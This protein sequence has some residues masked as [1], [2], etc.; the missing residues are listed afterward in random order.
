MSLTWDHL[1]LRSLD[2]DAAATFYET[3]FGARRRTRIDNGQTLRVIVDLAG[4]LLFIE[5]VPAGTA[6][7]PAPPFIGIEH[8]GLGVEEHDTTLAQLKGRGVEVISGPTDTGR[9]VRVAFVR[10]PD[11]VR[12]E[13]LQRDHPI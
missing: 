12:I 10:G 7:A 2:P 11:G 13:L 5:R 1:H 6:T 4:V 3:M 9:G 8:L